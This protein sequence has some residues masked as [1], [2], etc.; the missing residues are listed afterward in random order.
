MSALNVA[1][2]VDMNDFLDS[3]LEGTSRGSP[4]QEF[5]S[6]L[7]QL[8]LRSEILEI[9]LF[10]AQI[11]EGYLILS[12]NQT[13][14]HVVTTAYDLCS[15]HEGPRLVTTP[16]S[17]FSMV[18][19]L[20]YEIV[21]G[22]PTNE[23]LAGAINRFARSRERREKDEYEIKQQRDLDNSNDNFLITKEAVQKAEDDLRVYARLLQEGKQQLGEKQKLIISAALADAEARRLSALNAY[24]PHIVWFSDNP[25]SRL[26]SFDDDL[27]KIAAVEEHMKKLRIALGKARR[28]QRLNS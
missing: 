7:E 22:K 11:E 14:K 5:D 27:G 8:Q 21:G 17:D 1:V 13:K 6:F 19:S 10:R 9:C 26:K 2:A 18:C 3:Y 25:S 15:W 20:L 12:D 16:G 4:S 28:R 23:G 24:G